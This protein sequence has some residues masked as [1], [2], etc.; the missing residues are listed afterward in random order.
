VSGLNNCFSSWNGLSLPG[1]KLN[2]VIAG[3]TKENTEKGIHAGCL[4]YIGSDFLFTTV[5]N[6]NDAPKTAAVESF[7]QTFKQYEA[8]NGLTGMVIDLR[9]N[10]GDNLLDVQ[11]LFS[12]FLSKDMILA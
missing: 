5:K 12:N 11:V 10:A 3:I 7:I 9:E 2:L 6:E 1:G 8:T 4:Y